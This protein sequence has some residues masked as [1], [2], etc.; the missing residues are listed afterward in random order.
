MIDIDTI[1]ANLEKLA[2]ARTTPFCYSCYTEAPTGH[3]P[4]CG[5]DDMMRL[6]QGV[7]C[8]YGTE[9][10]VKEIVRQECTPIDVKTAFQLFME[11]L[12][13]EPVRV[14]FMEFDATDVMRELDPIAYSIAES[15]W[16]D[17][18]EAD[19]RMI[20][21]DLGSTWYDVDAIAEMLDASGVDF[22]AEDEEEHDIAA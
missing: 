11:E 4:K 17:S 6:M 5:S 7:G 1:K 8:E 16:V 19:D 14:G 9:W 2:L 12:Y 18:E 20:S 21:F 10:V 15:E 13:P 3:C 22:D